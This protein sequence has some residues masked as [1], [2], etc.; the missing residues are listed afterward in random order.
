[1]TAAVSIASFAV[2]LL[3]WVVAPPRC[4]ACD[5]PV[6]LLSVFCSACASTAERVQDNDPPVTAAFVYGGAVERAITRLKYDRRPDLARPLGDL[7]W[8]AL[9]P[10]AR[11]LRGSVVVPV[12]LH[13]SRLAQRGFNQAA[14]IARRVA[15]RIDAPLLPLALAR[16]RDTPQQAALDR[17][18]RI[19][20]VAG[21]FCTRQ[22]DRVRGRSVLLIDDVR[23]TGATM[24]ACASALL[25]AGAA[26][27]AHAVVAVARAGV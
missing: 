7:L 13:A 12:P 25:V 27:V 19:A 21:A 14:L 15:L 18:G 5:T 1:M 23:T 20:N 9:R 11:G 4:A 3:A 6:R 8:R 24:N 26:S 16:V 17:E 10:D 22:S 2:E